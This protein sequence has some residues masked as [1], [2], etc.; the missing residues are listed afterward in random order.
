[1]VNPLDTD[2][3]GVLNDVDNCPNTPANTVVD[4]NGCSPDQL[5]NAV[6]SPIA[7]LAPTRR[8]S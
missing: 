5:G 6:N 8:T 2:G 1:M 4:E 7:V 3:D